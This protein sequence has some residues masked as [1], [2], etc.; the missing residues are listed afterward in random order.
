MTQQ[1]T[2]ELQ[3]IQKVIR[4]TPSITVNGI[5]QKLNITLI[6]AWVRSVNLWKLG[7]IEHR[8]MLSATGKARAK[9]AKRPMAIDNEP[10]R[11]RPMQEGVAT[12]ALKPD[13]VSQPVAV[14]ISLRASKKAKL[15]DAEIEAKIRKILR[16]S[17]VASE[18]NISL[19]CQ[20]KV[21]PT[22]DRMVKAGEVVKVG[23]NRPFYKLAAKQADQAS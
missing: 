18:Q 3:Q 4:N 6:E 12:P 11:A 10:R 9:K 15:C 22:L 17:K 1:L 14:P 21:K 23:S 2:P 19:R 7:Y 8:P 16:T 20:C 13:P 5:A